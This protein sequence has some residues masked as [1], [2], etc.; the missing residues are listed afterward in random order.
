MNTIV[1]KLND[2]VTYV[3]THL[4]GSE[5]SA[6]VLKNT[7]TETANA[8]AAPAPTPPPIVGDAHDG[9]KSAG[10]EPPAASPTPPPAIPPKPKPKRTGHGRLPADAYRQA[11]HIDVPHAHL[12]PGDP[13]PSCNRG[14]L[15]LLPTPARILR[16]FGQA[17]LAAKCW[18][19]ERCRCGT[20]GHVFTAIAPPEA[21]GP[22]F[23]E[24]A[25]SM[26]AVCTYGAGIPFHRLECLQRNM[27]TPLP[28][29]TQWQIVSERVELVRPIHDELRRIA[30]QA[31]VVHTDDSY[32]RVL[33][34]MGVRRE[35]RVLAASDQARTLRRARA[36]RAGGGARRRV[37][38]S[39]AA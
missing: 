28:A 25:A 11:Q 32:V 12:R 27:E 18:D 22:K 24:S 36:R 21:Q 35:R 26:I 39:A 38:L 19:C 31:D 1:A 17:P 23:D 14:R 33:E 3:R 20:C 6:D 16:I 5:K 34:L 2:F 4:S 9:G 30:A 15:H 29:S 7:P 8:G 13:C 10:A 37:I